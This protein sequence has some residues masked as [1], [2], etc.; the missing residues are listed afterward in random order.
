MFKE[1]NL[2]DAAQALVNTQTTAPDC[3]VKGRLLTIDEGCGLSKVPVRRIV[4]GAPAKK[5]TWPWVALLGVQD[6]NGITF[7]CGKKTKDFSHTLS[8]KLIRIELTMR[9]H[10]LK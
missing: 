1:F 8:E 9:L 2:K 6:E 7:K 4:A 10:Y 5:Y 3:T